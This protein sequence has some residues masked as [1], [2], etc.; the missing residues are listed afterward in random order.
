[1]YIYLIYYYIYCNMVT[2][3]RG[4]KFRHFFSCLEPLLHNTMDRYIV[5]SL[6][7]TIEQYRSLKNCR[8]QTFLSLNF[9]KKI[10]F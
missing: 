1:M 4:M 6:S 5:A 7:L 3:I 2:D 8:Q 10:L 9:L